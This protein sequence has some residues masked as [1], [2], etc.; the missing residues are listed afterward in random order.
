MSNYLTFGGNEV[1]I[2]KMSWLPCGEI[3]FINVYAL[4]NPLHKI[5]LWE[6]MN[7]KRIHE[8]AIKSFMDIG[9]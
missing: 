6:L 3:G 5:N 2:L 1:K 4:S 7:L 8:V 9:T